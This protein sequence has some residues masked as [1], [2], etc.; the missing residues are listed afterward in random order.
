MWISRSAWEC[1]RRRV[2]RNEK[3]L[4]ELQKIVQNGTNPEET[5]CTILENIDI[6]I[7]TIIKNIQKDANNCFIGEQFVT[8]AV[9]NLAKLVEIKA[10]LDSKNPM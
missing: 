10:M 2:D 8:D 1:M 6:A 5:E 9:N 3:D 7:N 4:L